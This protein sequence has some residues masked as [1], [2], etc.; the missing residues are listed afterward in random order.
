MRIHDL[1]RFL[2]EWA[3]PAWQ[4][5]YDNSGLLVDAGKEITRALVSLD[6][7]EAVIDEALAKGCELVIAH[8]P[9]VFRGL[10]RFTGKTYVER[11]VMKAIREGVSLYAIHTN[12]DNVH[13]GVNAEIGRRLGLDNL[14]VLAPKKQLL[15]K[16]YTFVPHAQADALRQAIFASGAGGIGDYDECSFNVEGFGTFRGNE[17]TNPYVGQKLE[18][19]REPEVKIEVIFPA[20]MEQR[21]IG[22]LLAAHPYEEPA[23]DIIRLDN[24][25]LRS[26]AGMT[27]VLPEP[28]D[29]RAFLQR[30]KQ[31]FGCGIIRHTALVK[32][33]VQKVAFCG[34]SGFFLLPQAL[35]AGADIYLTADVKYHDFFDADGKIILADLGHFESEQF[36]KDLLAAAI[37]KKFPNF[38]VLISDTNTNPVNYL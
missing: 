16:L 36:T 29:S 9:I 10:K 23:Y 8:H 5:E 7:T 4:E 3:P 35:A 17:T 27:G 12:L 19:H 13:T 22:A 14:K 31:V 28:E 15:K 32:P 6:C 18:Q 2:E 11:T 21:V 37:Q 26:G 30:V 25:H 38:A 24:A 20:W 33:T 34:G 1:T